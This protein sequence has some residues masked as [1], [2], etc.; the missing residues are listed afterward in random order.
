MSLSI[1][2]RKRRFPL[3]Y[4]DKEAVH[5]RSGPLIKGAGQNGIGAREG[6]GGLTVE[7]SEGVSPVSSAARL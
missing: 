7:G 3:I 1:D 6:R 4:K 5:V 2:E